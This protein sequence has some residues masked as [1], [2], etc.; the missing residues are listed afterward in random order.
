[1]A[2]A[3]TITIPKDE[4]DVELTVGGKRVKLTNL[5]KPFWPDAGSRSAICSSTTPTSPP[6]SCRTSTTAR[7]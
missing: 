4:S 7:W 5:G 2:A 1:M 3:R 6:C